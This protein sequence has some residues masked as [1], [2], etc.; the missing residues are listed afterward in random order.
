MS[1]VPRPLVLACVLAAA[2]SHPAPAA[3][4]PSASDSRAPSPAAEPAPIQLPLLDPLPTIGGPAEVIFEHPGHASGPVAIACRPDAI[5]WITGDGWLGVAGDDAPPVV[6]HIHGEG[7]RALVADA[8]EVFAADD[9]AVHVVDLETGALEPRATLPLTNALALDGTHV[10]A[11]VLGDP[12]RSGTGGLHRFARRGGTPERLADGL[13]VPGRLAIDDEHVY[14]TETERGRIARAHRVRGTVEVLLDGLSKPFAIAIDGREVAFTEV[15]GTS[16]RERI[17]RLDLQ[18]R[19]ARVLV[20]GATFAYALV[21][22][23]SRV[24]W[25]GLGGGLAR[26]GLHDATLEVVAHYPDHATA[27]CRRGDTIAWIDPLGRKVLRA[28]IHA[29]RGDGRL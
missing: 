23:E 20:E 27:M 5:V 10:Y 1:A 14:W 9:E 12:A 15:G 3:P 17:S 4:E 29:T 2:C 7:L 26:V 24:Y 16:S 11:L 6:R 8:G 18:T 28:P 25:L 19:R 13:T 21:L 22:H